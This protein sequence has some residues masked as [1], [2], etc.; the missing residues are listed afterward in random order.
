MSEL[1]VSFMAKSIDTAP[2]DREIMLYMPDCKWWWQ[3]HYSITA[4]AWRM[5]GYGAVIGHESQ[6]QPTHWAEISEMTVPA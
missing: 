5:P 2:K 3:G 1:I 6:V 4:R